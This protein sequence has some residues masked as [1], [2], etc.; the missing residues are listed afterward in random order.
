MVYLAQE[1]PSLQ[2]LYF[3]VA[4]NSHYTGVFFYP[5]VPF[6]NFLVGRQPANPH[7]CWVFWDFLKISPIAAVAYFSRE[8]KRPGQVVIV[9]AAGGR[10]ASAAP[11]ASVGVAG[12]AAWG[13]APRPLALAR[14]LRCPL[15][16][17]LSGWVCGAP[18][19]SSLRAFRLSASRVLSEGLG[20]R[21]LA[22]GSAAAAL[23]GWVRVLG[24]PAPPPAA[25]AGCAVF[26]VLGVFPQGRCWSWALG[27]RARRSARPVPRL[28]RLP[29]G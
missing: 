22:L 14:Q 21:P 20:A 29:L 2:S 10:A 12:L 13:S 28:G 27:R 25:P 5:Q 17:L 16:G 1:G 23:S 3:G 4:S 11:C 7:G 18:R 6:D 24:R 8:G 9:R 26:A 15:R 19:P